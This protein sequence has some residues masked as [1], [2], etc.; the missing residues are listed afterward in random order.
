MIRGGF[1]GAEI[2]SYKVKVTEGDV[3]G[4]GWV[5]EKEWCSEAADFEV[6]AA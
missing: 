3:E 6:S 1:G 2:F 5:V 4:L